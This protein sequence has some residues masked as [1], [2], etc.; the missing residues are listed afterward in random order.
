VN[1]SVSAT[2]SPF[3]FIALTVL[4]LLGAVFTTAS[5][6]ERPAT[7]KDFEHLNTGFP[8]RGAH[9]HLTCEQ[10]HVRGI[11][12]GTPRRC[13]GCH[14]LATDIEASKKSPNHIPTT[15]DCD[16]CHNDFLPN[17]SWQLVN[18]NHAGIV[19]NCASCHNNV[20][21]PGKPPNHLPTNAPCETCHRSTIAWAGVRFDHVGVSAGCGQCHNNVTVAGKPANHIPT[22]QACET[23]HVSTAAWSAVRMNHEGI[24]SGCARC[25]NNVLTIGQPRNHIPVPATPCETCHNPAQF[26]T[27]AGARMDHTG[28]NITHGCQRCHEAG[29]IYGITS[30]PAPPHPQPNVAPDCSQCHLNTHSFLP[31][32]TR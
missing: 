8:L 1:T 29:N 30:R 22:G 14:Q 15:E 21:A 24:A 19:N 31:V 25:H 10:C 26:H 6:A 23:C 27:F 13:I 32:F 4:V 5:A 7:P 20:F 28:A 2:T 3:T 9:E 12:K 17:V 16:V 11:F 18:M